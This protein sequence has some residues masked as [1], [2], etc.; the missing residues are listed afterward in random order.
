MFWTLVLG[1]FAML[2]L[3]VAV[4]VFSSHKTSGP[5]KAV[6]M[7]QIG[8]GKKDTSKKTDRPVEEHKEAVQYGVLPEKKSRADITHLIGIDPQL[9]AGP[10]SHD[11]T[12][13][14]VDEDGVITTPYGNYAMG[15]KWVRAIGSQDGRLLV[16]VSEEDHKT[17]H[18]MQRDTMNEVDGYQPWKKVTLLDDVANMTFVLDSFMLYVRGANGVDRVIRIPENVTDKDSVPEI[19]SEAPFKYD[20]VGIE[21]RPSDNTVYV[22]HS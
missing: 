22:Y 4:G 19:I 2:V 6:D 16:S 7:V 1:L 14:D 17:L 20:P 18:I 13:V 10:V 8:G 5:E 11:H 9:H 15:E 3:W 12:Q 21:Y